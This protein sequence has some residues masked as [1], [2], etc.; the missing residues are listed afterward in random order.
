MT[1]AEIE[2]L[3]VLQS[4]NVRHLARVLNA[5]NRDVNRSIE[6]S[7]DLEIQYRTKILA[8]VYSAWSEAQFL[9]IAYTP[10]GFYVPEV[11]AITN[12]KSNN[13]VAAGWKLMLERAMTRVGDPAL[14]NDL[15]DRL[16]KL[17][18]ITQEYIGEPSIIR[19]K[20]AH[21]QWVNVLNRQNTAKN[22]DLTQVLANLD[23]VLV[24][25]R[26]SIHQ[27]FGYI[28]RDL[29]QS[30]RVGFHRHYWTNIVNLESY[31]RRSEGWTLESKKA[32]LKRQA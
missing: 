25:K 8:F 14:N 30:P 22:D 3:Y 32:R 5:L 24:M 16:S 11:N 1:P 20:I 29:V 7:N 17:I 12:A 18:E 9:Q 10:G 26:K 4:E 15:R 2:A 21:G 23:P 27:F 6:R 31:L 28:A 19:N 13:G